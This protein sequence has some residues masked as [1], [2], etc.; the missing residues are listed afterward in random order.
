LSGVVDHLA[1]NDLHAL[2]LARSIVSHLNRAKPQAPFAAPVEPK[3]PAQELYG[4]IPQDTRK[5]FDVREVIA[6]ST[7]SRRATAPP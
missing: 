5:P 3:Y 1:Q 7:N 4:V 2:A 6:N